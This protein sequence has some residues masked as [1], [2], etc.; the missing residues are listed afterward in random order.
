MQHRVTIRDVAARAGV[1][2]GAVSLALNGRPGVSEATRRRITEAARDLGWSPN[3]AARSLGR[4]PQVHTIGMAIS[5]EA[6]AGGL[7]ALHMALI[8]GI[9]SVLSERPCS[10]L[11]HLTTSREAEIALYRKWWQSGQVNGAVLTGVAADDPRIQPMQHLGIPVV[12]VAHPDHSGPFPAVWSD[13]AAAISEAMRYLAV[14]G[15]R[16]LA[17][18]TGPVGLGSALVRSKAFQDTA[19]ELSLDDHRSVH[20]DLSAHQ[21]ARVTRT[22][23]AGADRPTAIVY[24]NDIMAVAGLAVTAEL[25]LRV[26]E[27]VSLVAWDDSDLCQITRPALSALSHDPFAFGSQ[28]ARCLLRLLDTGRA[29]SRTSGTSVLIPR[30]TTGPLPRRP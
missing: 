1:S 8:G 7:D 6:G 12:A 2:A 17:H 3:L 5:R 30:G 16:R 15:H 21:G 27:D 25:G 11:L 19:A 26:P 14:L 24:D 9:E 28:V 10:L 13:D 18:V 20:T 29:E 23:L 4:G 22:L